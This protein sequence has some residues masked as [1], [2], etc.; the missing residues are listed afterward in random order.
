MGV[1]LRLPQ[2]SYDE[3]VSIMNPEQREKDRRRRHKSHSRHKRKANSSSASVVESV[4]SEPPPSIPR[5]NGPVPSQLQQE[6]LDSKERVKLLASISS[7]K[8]KKS[9]YCKLD[10]K[11]R[12]VLAKRL[13][14]D[15][16]TDRNGTLDKNELIPLLGALAQEL[17]PGRCQVTEDHAVVVL[18]RCDLNADQRL[19]LEEFLDALGL[20]C[21]YLERKLDIDQAIDRYDVDKSDSLEMGELHIV[22]NELDEAHKFS[23]PTAQEVATTFKMADVTGDGNIDRMELMFA[24]TM[25]LVAKERQSKGNQYHPTLHDWILAKLKRIFQ[26]TPDLNIQDD[27]FE[28]ICKISTTT[29]KSQQAMLAYLNNFLAETY[30]EVP[31]SVQ[32]LYPKNKIK[33][34]IDAF[35]AELAKKQ[36]DANSIN[37]WIYT[38]IL[39]EKRSEALQKKDRRL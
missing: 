37:P 17:Y 36:R 27:M 1:K 21:F 7:K 32:R 30:S 39:G 8:G 11:E 12:R 6:P 9:A 26:F 31:P 19:D 34:M 24:I 25:H 33:G 22:L 14:Y 20:W 38:D 35:V 2:L 5:D 16:D 29:D 13:I 3:Y 10:T 15:F 28:E 4:A 18:K 23:A